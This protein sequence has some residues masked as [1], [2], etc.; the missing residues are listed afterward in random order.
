[1]VLP[2]VE[3]LEPCPSSGPARVGPDSLPALT[4]GCLGAG[5]SVGL[6][7]LSAGVPMVVNL[8]ASWCAPCQ[9]ELP[10]FQRLHER[11]GGRLTVLGVLT[12]D[13]SPLWR[14]SLLASGVRY[15]SVR[16]DDGTLLARERGVGLPMTLLVR[17]DGS[18]ASRY[19]GPA[20]DDAALAALV[21]TNLGL[22]L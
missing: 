2:A 20:L 8:W 18:V 6:A 4:L 22:H 21:E 17:A 11:A 15:P 1:E 3:G 5:P 10:A 14:D 9:R 19:I 7:G 12:K 16:D 13:P